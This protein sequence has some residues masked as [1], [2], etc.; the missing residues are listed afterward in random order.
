MTR[1][2]ITK[3]KF[4]KKLA[5]A[6]KQIPNDDKNQSFVELIQNAKAATNKINGKYPFNMLKLAMIKRL[7]ITEL[8]I[9]QSQPIPKFPKGGIIAKGGINEPILDTTEKVINKTI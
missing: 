4:L 9:I 6:K 1:F 3:R 8:M 2:T 7:F 5:K